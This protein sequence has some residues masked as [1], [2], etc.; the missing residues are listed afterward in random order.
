MGSNYAFSSEKGITCVEG[1]K[2][3]VQASASKTSSFQATNSL[4]SDCRQARLF[5]IVVNVSAVSG[6]SP[7][8]AI[9]LQCS[10]DDSTYTDIDGAVM[11]T[12]T[13]M[14]R[15]NWLVKGPFRWK[16]V[17]PYGTLGGTTPNFTLTIDCFAEGHYVS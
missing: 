6:T 16:Y 9:K 11:T 10:D 15:Y 1:K 17:K 13:A 5:S 2:T 12:I 3:A 8:L 7:T 14:G 4:Y